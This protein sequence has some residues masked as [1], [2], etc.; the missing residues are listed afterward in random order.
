MVIEMQTLALDPDQSVE[1]IV[2]YAFA[3]ARKLN[4]LEASG[5]AQ[6]E[7]NGYENAAEVPKYRVLQS[8]L[9]AWNPAMGWTPVYIDDAQILEQLKEVRLNI[10]IGEIAKLSKT[11]GTIQYEIPLNIVQMLFPESFALGIVPYKI[12]GQNTLHGVV[13]IVRNQILEW[14]LEL[15]AK[16]VLGEGMTFSP[17]EKEAASSIV[18]N[19]SPGGS[20]TSVIS[21][22]SSGLA[23]ST[24]DGS[25]SVETG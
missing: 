22:K 1:A 24:G 21:Q 8:W 7:L 11:E 15:E 17:G 23:I 5:W 18:F 6:N 16:G 12:V 20:L 14:S 19:V 2:R 10:P 4:D 25:S 13:E 3:A 9:K